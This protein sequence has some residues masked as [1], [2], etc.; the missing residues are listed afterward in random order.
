MTIP[1]SLKRS[2]PGLKCSWFR[3]KRVGNEEAILARPNP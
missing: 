1:W 2:I 3:L